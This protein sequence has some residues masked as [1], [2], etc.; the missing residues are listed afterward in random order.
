[1][2]RQ[3]IVPPLPSS[4]IA[5][6]KDLYNGDHE[7]HQTSPLAWANP[8][9]HDRHAWAYETLAGG[10]STLGPNALVVKATTIG[11]NSEE[12]ASPGA[13]PHRGDTFAKVEIEGTNDTVGVDGNPPRE[14]RAYSFDIMVNPDYVVNDLYFEKTGKKVQSPKYPG[15]D[16][17][18]PAGGLSPIGLPYPNH[19]WATI[20]GVPSDRY[21]WHAK[22]EPL[23]GPGGPTYE[24]GAIFEAPE[25]N[26]QKIRLIKTPGYVEVGVGWIP[27]TMEDSWELVWVR[28]AG[29]STPS[30]VTNPTQVFVSAPTPVPGVDVT[31]AN[32]PAPHVS[33][34]DQ[35]RLLREKLEAMMAELAKREEELAKKTPSPLLDPN[36]GKPL[37]AA[38]L[39][40]APASST[41]PAPVSPASSLPLA[42]ALPSP[43]IKEVRKK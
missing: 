4:G 25:G 7:T 13:A 19:P 40:L 32:P 26:Y 11:W 14:I 5:N 34:Y 24:V 18:N 6:P 30:M 9:F 20:D 31:K 36:T 21:F 33:E 17:R 3:T 43:T 38:P 10:Q 29:Q 37:G 41:S 15:Y 42:P 16:A 2:P 28:S 1:M 23:G 27:A 8:E 39:P 35:I 12:S 22:T